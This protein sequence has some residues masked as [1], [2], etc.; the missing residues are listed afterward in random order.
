ML[1][2]C[3]DRNSRGDPVVKVS[4]LCSLRYLMGIEDEVRAVDQCEDYE[5]NGRPRWDDE[6]QRQGDKP[7]APAVSD[8]LFLTKKGFT[9]ATYFIFSCL[10]LS[11][12]SDFSP[13][14][15]APASS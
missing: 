3:Q 4:R 12:T 1:E 9:S 10:Y 6:T 7:S 13:V 11:N 2:V 8:Q 5:Q 14:G 15:A